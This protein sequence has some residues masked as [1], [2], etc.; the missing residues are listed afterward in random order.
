VEVIA[1]RGREALAYGPLKPV[2]LVDPRTGKR[3]YA[4]VQ[5]RQDNLA[6][7]LYNMV[8]FQTNLRWGEQE[9]VFRLIPGLERAQFVRFGQMHRNTF[10][11]SPVL[12]QPTMQF[13]ARD[14]LFFGGQITGTEGYVGSTA[15][16]L[17]AGLN[18]ARRMADKPLI[19]F[20]ATTMLGALCRYVT[21]AEPESFQPMK[22]NF[23]LMPALER[24]VRRKRD[25]HHA[26]TQRAL[27]DLAAAIAG[28]VGDGPS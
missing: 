13:K 12:L 1:R 19:V 22:P 7:T 9:R 25:R 15:S 23:G 28:Q 8:G 3:P 17:V 21:S 18:A 26:Y 11:N 27:A 16:G 10:I 24:P 2:G 4:V 20:P 5:L 14:N 6:G